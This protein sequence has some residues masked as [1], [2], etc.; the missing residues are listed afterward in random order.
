M[1]QEEQLRE[2]ELKRQTQKERTQLELQAN[3]SKMVLGVAT[4]LIFGAILFG[5]MKGGR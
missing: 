1:Q 5:A 2:F 3:Q 4:A